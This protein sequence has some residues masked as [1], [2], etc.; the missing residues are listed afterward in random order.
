MNK[1]SI[2]KENQSNND[3][4]PIVYFTKDLSAEGLKKIYSKVNQNIK[5]KVAIKL[6]T[7]EKNGPNILPREWVKEFMASVPNST[8]VETNS[9][10]TGDRD[11]T[12]KHKE[13]LKVN[14]WA[15]FTTVDIMDEDGAVMLPIKNGTHFKEMSM[16]SHILNYDSMIALTHFKG[17]TMGGFGG[18]IKNLAIGNADG[19]IGKKMQH[20]TGMDVQNETWGVSGDRFMENMVE[21]VMATIQHFGK[22]I[23][24]INVMRKM[25]VDC[26]CAGVSAAEPK[27]RDIGILG[28]TDI[29][30]L[31]QA[32]IDLL[33]TLPEEEKHDLEERIKTRSGMRQLTYAEEK[34][35]GSRKYKLVEIK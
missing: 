30:A 16:G 35:L 15:D 32:C 5:G 18:S 22:Q 21:S 34:G 28:S 7:G 13:T 14:G 23:T 27:A 4:L 1:D 6:H 10:Y 33:H 20:E 8:I 17:H 3:N 19:K 25:S 31:D 12:E 9:Y 29:V 26:D 2:S 11:T 24:F